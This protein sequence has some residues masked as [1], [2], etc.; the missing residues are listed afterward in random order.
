MH[1]NLKMLQYYNQKLGHCI[2]GT[3]SSRKICVKMVEN[4]VNKRGFVV[5]LFRKLSRAG[6]R[7]VTRISL[8]SPSLF[9]NEEN[10]TKVF[11]T[12]LCLLAPIAFT[13]SFRVQLAS[14]RV[15]PRLLPLS[16]QGFLNVQTK[17]LSNWV[18]LHDQIV[19]SKAQKSYV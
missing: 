5:A 1:N 6:F 7:A 4:K 16:L 14:R 17:L 11:L 12:K 2:L 9:Q 8:L 15:I 19:S 3:I 18:K 13:T 10:D